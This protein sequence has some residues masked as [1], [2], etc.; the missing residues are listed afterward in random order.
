MTDRRLIVAE[1]TG[2]G[3]RAI[4]TRSLQTGNGLTIGREAELCVGADPMDPRVSRHAVTVEC[5][6]EGWTIWATN[7]NGLLV[8]PWGLAAWLARPTE[9]L[10]D[11]RAALRV[12]GSAGRE[13]W[14]LLE[15]DSRLGP[16]AAGG[17]EPGQ[18]ISTE[19]AAPARPLTPP[20]SKHCA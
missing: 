10:T 19:M 20:R 15:D 14:V 18:P 16:A 9:F 4:A 17:P 6:E 1:R 13:H 8:H 11:N 12:L 2:S 7:R 3:L 5:T